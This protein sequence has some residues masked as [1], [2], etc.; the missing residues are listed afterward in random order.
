MGQRSL[1]VTANTY[2]HVL[3][4]ETEIDY[5]DLWS[6]RPRAV[7]ATQRAEACELACGRARERRCSLRPGHLQR[8]EVRVGVGEHAILVADVDRVVAG[9]RKPLG[10][11]RGRRRDPKAADAF[12][13]TTAAK[14]GDLE[15][16][17]FG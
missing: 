12:G 13:D 2:T 15:P 8:S 9:V 6:Q 11:G 14:K 3:V 1:A 7:R 17:T 16:A 10:T 5:A 4:D